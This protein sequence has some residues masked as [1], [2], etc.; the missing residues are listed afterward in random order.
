MLPTQQPQPLLISPPSGNDYRPLK[1]SILEIP[2]PPEVAVEEYTAWQLSRMST[3]AFKENIR[4][5]RDVTLEN[6][7]DLKQIYYDQNPAFFVQ[8][9]IKISITRRFVSEI[10]E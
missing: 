2:G 8:V 1:A 3:D 6:Y 9:S 4:K 5:A 10:D 7:L